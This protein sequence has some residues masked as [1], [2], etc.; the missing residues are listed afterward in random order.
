MNRWY[1]GLL[2]FLLLPLSSNAQEVYSL[3]F[4]AKAHPETTQLTGF[5]SKYYANYELV[6]EGELDLRVAAGNELVVDETGVYIQKNKVLSISREEVRENSKY[7]VRGGYL[8]GVVENDSVMVALADEKYFFLMPTK[9]YLFETGAITNQLYKGASP[10]EFF[11]LNSEDN[12]YQSIISIRFSGNQVIL[13]D[14]DYEQTTFDFRTVTGKKMVTNDGI[15]TYILSPTKKEWQTL[16]KYFVAYD[17][18]Q[19]KI[20]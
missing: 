5:E 18:Y 13:L 8:H 4:A 20:S 2:F 3:Y 9:S 10:N 17:T 12:G 7:L 14:L 19:R 6:G 15:P 16:M 11:I 1:C